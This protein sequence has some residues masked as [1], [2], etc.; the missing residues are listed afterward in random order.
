MARS[1]HTYTILMVFAANLF[2]N[3]FF[4][5]AFFPAVVRVAGFFYCLLLLHRMRYGILT[6]ACAT[7]CIMLVKHRRIW[8]AS[9]SLSFYRT[10]LAMSN[11]HWL[12]R[13]ILLERLFCVLFFCFFCRIFLFFPV[14]NAINII[15]IQIHFL[16]VSHSL[17][18]YVRSC[19]SRS[20]PFNLKQTEN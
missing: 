19:C 1:V 3:F 16:S 5:R 2:H 7:L 4:T 17:Y 15:I 14:F 10:C 9:Q 18:L 12:I 8:P 13:L 20:L 6:L 11:D